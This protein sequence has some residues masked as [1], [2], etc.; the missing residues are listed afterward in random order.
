MPEGGS[1]AIETRS[2]AGQVM[3]QVSDTGAGMTEEVRQRCLDPFFTTKGSHGTGMGLAMVYGIVQRHQG[4]MDI[5]TQLG[6]GTS[7]TLRFP[8][9]SRSPVG[10]I[11]STAY[12]SSVEHLRV[13]VVDDEPTVLALFKE[14]LELDGHAVSAAA[15]GRQAADMFKSGAFDLV[16]TDR[17]M[18]EMSG[19]QLAI[20]VKRL[21]PATPVVLIT[22]F[23]GIMLA[24]D[25]KPAGVDLVLGKPVGIPE[26]RQAIAR[27][28]GLAGPDCLEAAGIQL[29]D[30]NSSLEL[31]A[32]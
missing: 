9:A 5:K 28:T 23:G 6:Q 22:G 2:E 30:Q 20:A 21:S 25:E 26:L 32:A 13:L 12:Q 19:D 16:L 8:T 11:T 10:V 7:F 27:V 29:P 17:A 14:Y 24:T 4:K 31:V 3:L 18:P 15:N 1:I